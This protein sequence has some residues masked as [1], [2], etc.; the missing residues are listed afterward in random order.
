[1]KKIQ[2]S[3]ELFARI[4]SYFL[5]NKAEPDQVA[6]IKSQLE[7]KLERMNKRDEYSKKWRSKNET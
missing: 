2:I 7:E 1:M 6:I 4:C 5:F 3:E